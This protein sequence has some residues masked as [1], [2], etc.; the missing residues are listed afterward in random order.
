M[1]APTAHDLVL[2]GGRVVDPANGVDVFADLA[3][4]DGRIAAI[5]PQLQGRQQLD[6]RGCVVAPGFIDL[7]S[8]A[9][10][11]TGHRL[12]AHDGVTTTLELEA[13]ASPVALAYSEAAEQ[14][15]PLNYGYSASWAHIRMSVLTGVA[16]D[17]HV[18]TILNSLGRP[19]WQRPASAAQ[20]ATILSHLDEELAAGA[21]GVGLLVGYSPGV[22]GS[23]YAR[24]SALAR[25]RNRPTFTHA[26]DLSLDPPMILEAE[27]AGT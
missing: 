26:R 13:G 20:V 8:H 16:R 3:V 12:Q 9:Q 15:R 21:L 22:E 4:H 19:E 11:L 10:D 5:G 27:R 17:G 23:E 25:K 24:V 14:G 7:H 18:T 1:T 6:A 2:L